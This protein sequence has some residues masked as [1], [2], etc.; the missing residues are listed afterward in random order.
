LTT[1]FPVE[2]YQP[3]MADNH[4]EEGQ[5]SR[6]REIQESID[7]LQHGTPSEPHSMRERLNHSAAEFWRNHKKKDRDTPEKEARLIQ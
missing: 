2:V 3:Y 1:V 7:S 4:R 5:I 6:A